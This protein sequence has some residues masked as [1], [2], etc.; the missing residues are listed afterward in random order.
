[1][2]P[3]SA[4]EPEILRNRR[5]RVRHSIEEMHRLAGVARRQLHVH[6]ISDSSPK[7]NWR[8]G[9]GH[10][11]M[12]LAGS[13]LRGSWCPYCAHRVRRSIDEMRQIAISRGGECLSEEYEHL[14]T[15]LEWRCAAG[16][17]WT[18]PAGAIAAGKWCMQCSL[19]EK[20]SSRRDPPNGHRTWGPMRVVRL[21]QFASA[22]RVGVCRRSQLESLNGFDSARNMVSYLRQEPATCDRGDA[23]NRGIARRKMPLSH[24]CQQPHTAIVVLPRRA[25]MAGGSEQCPEGGE[26]MWNL[27]PGMCRAEQKVS[28]PAHSR[29]RA[30][31]CARS[32]RQVHF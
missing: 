10:A 9:Q 27:V 26:E 23:E 29:R 12:A 16:H 20:Y 32:R 1:M 30:G 25:P 19:V 18:A 4:V 5:T 7:L 2:C 24:I 22:D 28:G 14:R 6:I 13:V 11:W 31:D 8:C 21:H 15:A 3:S 17:V